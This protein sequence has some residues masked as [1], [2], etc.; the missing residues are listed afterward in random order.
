MQSRSKQKI[1]DLGEK[2]SD[3]A[4][5][6][7]VV[8]IGVIHTCSHLAGAFEDF[9]KRPPFSEAGQLLARHHKKQHAPG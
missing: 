2:K 9:R 8:F 7:G 4:S 6:Q 5:K 3:M 1:R